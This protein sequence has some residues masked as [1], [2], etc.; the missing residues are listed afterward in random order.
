M[1]SSVTEQ[2]LTKGG[3][4]G[5]PLNDRVVNYT[6]DK[7]NRILTEHGVSDA[8]EY[9]VVYEYGLTGNR[10]SRAV[11]VDNDTYLH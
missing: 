10:L 7:L 3:N 8:N 6:Y 2:I 11:T 9:S 4:P 1:R 5:W